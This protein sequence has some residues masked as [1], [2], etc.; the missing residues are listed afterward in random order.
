MTEQSD[1]ARILTFATQVGAPDT[2]PEDTARARGWLDDAGAPTDEGR[3][4]VKSLD[5][6]TGTRSVFR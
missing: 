4:L 5:D 2:P 3:A 1:T 6:Q